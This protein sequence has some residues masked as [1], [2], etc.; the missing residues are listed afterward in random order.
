MNP[1]ALLTTSFERLGLRGAP[2]LLRYLSK[3][4]LAR[5]LA[6]VRLPAGQSICFPAYD[7]YWARY[8]YAG[9]P[10]EPDVEAVFRRFAHGRTLVDC[11]ANIGYWSA[12]A[13]ELGFNEAVAIEANEALIPL[14]ERNHRGRNLH[15]AVHSR[16]GLTMCLGGEGAAASLRETG[17]PVRTIALADLG[18]SGPALVKLDVEGSEVAAIEGAGSLDAVYV[19]EDWPRSGMPVTRW[20]LEEGFKVSGFDLTPIRD[21]SDA[22]A[23]NRRTTQSYGP[24]NLIAMR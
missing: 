23:F 11:G 7:E 22:F 20:L 18:I 19:Y 6:T 13:A 4:R 8:L 17:K 2:T 16:S 24:S 9:V 14:L 15:A 10:Y 1:P 21:L 3:T 12:R 5:Q